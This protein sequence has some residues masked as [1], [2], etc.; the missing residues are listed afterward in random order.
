[1]IR[2]ILVDVPGTGTLPVFLEDT[3]TGITGKDV[4][5]RPGA[6]E[7][8]KAAG[9]V[10]N[11][12]EL[13]AT[14]GGYM[15]KMFGLVIS[16]L[17]PS[18]FED[19]TADL[20]R[21]KA[22]P[23]TARN[24]YLNNQPDEVRKTLGAAFDT[25]DV[26]EETTRGSKVFLPEEAFTYVDPEVAAKMRSG[27]NDYALKSENNRE[28]IQA[29]FDQQY[30]IVLPSVKELHTAGM[31]TE[32]WPQ[33][34]DLLRVLMPCRKVVKQ[35]VFQYNAIYHTPHYKVAPQVKGAL[36][37]HLSWLLGSSQN[38][39]LPVQPYERHMHDNL[40]TLVCSDT[41]TY[42]AEIVTGIML[43]S[44]FGSSI[45]KLL[46]CKQ[47]DMIE[48]LVADIVEFV[49]EEI[50]CKIAA[51]DFIP[52]DGST[53][54]P[55]AMAKILRDAIHVEKSAIK[56]L[57]TNF[58]AYSH[59]VDVD[60]LPFVLVLDAE[61][62]DLATQDLIASNVVTSAAFRFLQH[63]CIVACQVNWGHT[64]AFGA[65]PGLEI[66]GNVDIVNNVYTSYIN[67]RLGSIKA[68]A[69]EKFS[70]LYPVISDDYGDED[71]SSEDELSV[72]MGKY[73]TDQTA[74]AL[75]NGDYGSEYFTQPT[76]GATNTETK[77]V[78]Y[79]REVNGEN[80][81][82]NFLFSVFSTTGD[83]KTIIDCF[84]KLARWGFNK[85]NLLVIEGYPSV[86][87]V[88][89]LNVCKEFHNTSIVDENTLV[90]VNGC[91]YTIASAL[92]APS[93]GTGVDNTVVGLLL[94]RDYGGVKKYFAASWVDI[95]EMVANSEVDIA[96]LKTVTT[97]SLSP[98]SMES[99]PDV[100]KS[101]YGYH[102]S[103]KNIDLGMKYNIPPAELNELAML[104]IPGILMS[105]EYIRSKGNDVAITTKDRQYQ[106]LATYV[107]TMREIYRMRSDTLTA[108]Q[109][110][111]ADIAAIAKE[112]YNIY[113]AKA[114]GQAPD[115]NTARAASTLGSLNLD[116]GP[117][118]KFATGDLTGK[119][120]LIYDWDMQSKAPAMVFSD[121]KV[122]SVADKLR[123]SVV[124]LAL[125][126]DSEIILCRKDIAASEVLV[127]GGKIACRKYSSYAP[128]IAKAKESSTVRVNIDGVSKEAKLHESI[129]EFI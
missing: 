1:M 73:L 59:T 99:L 124:M 26:Y 86:K 46:N 101:I 109:I 122:Q 49:P 119:F 60:N 82:N 118:I 48:S 23:A 104:G 36:L 55:E 10:L 93:M 29:A 21:L 17:D 40:Y 85:P 12:V 98:D 94:C 126:T 14:I 51:S 7:E 58:A 79:W 38:N 102:V 66:R 8:L 18:M 43:R 115:A 92:T 100:V 74:Y 5:T 27:R 71:N 52:E 22:Q 87:N 83:I 37:P 111:T 63:M 53:M 90:R 114:A 32:D 25:L 69:N 123:N 96:D 105:P 50:S 125:E 116:D 80:N 70:L 112:V 78:E 106:I 129:S 44:T 3:V 35:G 19:M 6:Y 95:G 117:S 28:I 81:L 103:A 57:I 84:I 65:L 68:P 20:A 56:S 62:K 2:A 110:T 45:Q 121:A 30:G 75:R 89:D 41:A 9:H 88:F 108:P 15:T 34:V 39:L 91:Q 33:N 64:G 127:S 42:A 113:N 97:I 4:M 72:P 107:D 67:D 120:A 16:N 76:S 77:L 54:K 31:S 24:I 13:Q 128:I 11:L 61:S 47:A